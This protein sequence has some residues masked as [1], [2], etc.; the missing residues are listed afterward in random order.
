MLPLK[1]K[2]PQRLANRTRN[3]GSL[4]KPCQLP[5]KG[6]VAI[7]KGFGPTGFGPVALT[8]GSRKSKSA[9]VR[10]EAECHSGVV[11]LPF[12]PDLIKAAIDGRLP[13]GMGIARLTDLPAE[14][15]KQREMLGFP[16]H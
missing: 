10:R 14:W 2:F 15:S 9:G 13:Y 1:H 5:R 3:T 8:V 16:S 4:T 12:A 6:I 11:R 7:G